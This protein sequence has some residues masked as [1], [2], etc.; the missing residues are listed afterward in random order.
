MHSVEGAGEV[1]GDHPV[2]LGGGEI[3]HRGDV[4]NAGIVDEDI[5]AAEFGLGAG[6]HCVDLRGLADIG[7]IIQH[8]DAV[9]GG[10]F[11]A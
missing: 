4:L 8:T 3:F 9:G 2:P 10:E 7:A 11:G 5:E 6:H 1:D